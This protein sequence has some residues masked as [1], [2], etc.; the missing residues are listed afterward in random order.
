MTESRGTVEWVGSCYGVDMQAGKPVVVRAERNRGRVN[1]FTVSVNDPSF[2]NGLQNG[3]AVVAGCLSAGESFSCWLESPFLSYRKAL[4]VLPTL[5]DVQLP[6]AL[7]ECVYGF[8]EMAQ[9]SPVGRNDE[10]PKEPAPAGNTGAMRALAVAARME[11]VQKKMESFAVFGLDPVTFDYEGLALWT[12]SF[13][14]AP[15]VAGAGDNVFRVVIYLGMER[16]T[17]VIGRGMEFIS[18]HNISRG[19]N[20]AAQISRLL[21][22]QLKPEPGRSADIRWM[23]A[24]PGAGD[25]GLV[26]KLQESLRS[27][28]PGPSVVHDKPETFLARA[29][30][31]RALTAGPLRCNLRTGPF[32]HPFITSRVEKETVR[33]A[34][35][36]LAAGLLMCAVNLAWNTMVSRKELALETAT[37]SLADKLAGYHVAAKG[38]G[39]VKVV[40]DA[41]SPRKEMLKPFLRNFEPS[42]MEVIGAITDLAKKN[43]LHYESL[44]ISRE[45]VNISGTAVNWRKCD[46]LMDFLK[47]KGYAVRMDRKES[48]SDERIAFSI[49]PT[50]GAN[51]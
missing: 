18:A 3:K 32:V 17:M 11:D 25:A 21:K 16:S 45:K 33:T 29:V 13:A 8:V 47:Q 44:S 30:A 9:K 14:E 36:Y 51:E 46:V 20:S 27:E 37:S 41:L 5:L 22:A 1:C 31:T 10:T 34:L 2:L 7:E 39:R 28:W 48:L 15:S 42:L 35:I 4:K 24:G 38:E 49:I 6:F 12:Q 40:R 43:D 26:G 50:G 19:Q 23:W